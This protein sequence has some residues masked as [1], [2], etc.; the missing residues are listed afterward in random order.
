MFATNGVPDLTTNGAIERFLGFPLF[1]SLAPNTGHVKFA[2][3]P[4]REGKTHVF[5]A[6]D[7][8]SDSFRGG[9]LFPSAAEQ[10]K[11]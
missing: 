2:E 9:T 7:A 5:S 8:K 10:V 11:T 3:S 4:T 6:G 1:P